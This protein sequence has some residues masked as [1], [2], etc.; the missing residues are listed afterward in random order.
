MLVG[1]VLLNNDDWVLVL[2]MVDCRVISIG[3][4]AAHPLRGE[5]GAV[6]LGHGTTVLVSDDAGH[7]MLVDPSLPVRFWR[8]GCLSGRGCGRVILRMFF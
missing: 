1:V 2:V 6:R 8:R 4:L 3:A 7:R 5:K